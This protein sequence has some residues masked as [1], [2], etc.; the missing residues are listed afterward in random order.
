MESGVHLNSV[1]F[2]CAAIMKALSK[3]KPY[4][5]S[6]PDGIHPLLFKHLGEQ[7]AKLLAIMF[8]SFFL[9][10]KYQKS[11]PNR[12]SYQYLKLAAHP[13]WQITGLFH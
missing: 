10:I 6:G 13:A 3:L 8:T 7:T 11:G 2:D 12:L 9:S 4:L 5:A 1:N